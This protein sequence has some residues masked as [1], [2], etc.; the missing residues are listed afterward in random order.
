M[1]AQEGW[2][3]A[4]GLIVMGPLPSM[5]KL[6]AKPSQADGEHAAQILEELLGEFPFCG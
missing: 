3:P 4:T 2:D 5:P 1:L 6:A